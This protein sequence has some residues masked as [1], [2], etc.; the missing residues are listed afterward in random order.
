LSIVGR[1]RLGNIDPAGSP[2]FSGSTDTETTNDSCPLPSSDVI[3]ARAQEAD[4]LRE[5]LQRVGNSDR[6]AFAEL[7]D[8]TSARL[9]GMVLRV[10]RNP[11]YSE[12]TTQEIY[13]QIWS[14]ASKYDPNRGSPLAWMMTMAHRRAIDRVRSEQS[15]ANREAQY[16]W[17]TYTPDHDSVVETV[18]QR[19][20][21]D[22]VV[23]C[24]HTLT[25]TQQEA[26]R[27]AY[28]GGLTYREVGKKLAVALPTVKS[29][30][31]E[32]LLK[33]KNCLGVFTDE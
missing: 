2:D 25:A 18:A 15:G 13:L 22:A 10:L 33:L 17:S 19:D 21:A 7:Y 11:G 23:A 12:E 4:H 24:L 6:E 29:R 5:L 16:G 27:L 30:I 32:G 26:V 1:H 14:T 9:Y 8:A 31:R 28:Y 3:S 20:E